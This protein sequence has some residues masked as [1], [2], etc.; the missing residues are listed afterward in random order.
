MFPTVK[1]VACLYHGCGVTMGRDSMRRHLATI[2]YKAK[3]ACQI[4]GSKKRLNDSRDRLVHFSGCLEELM[5]R[6]PR[7]RTRPAL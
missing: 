1:K 4:C 7:F 3:W 2:H 6:D 5:K